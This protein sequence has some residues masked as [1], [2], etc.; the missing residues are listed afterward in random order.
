[1]ANSRKKKGSQGNSDTSDSS[2]RGVGFGDW[3]PT[4]QPILSISSPSHGVGV[5]GSS[6]SF[7][8]ISQPESAEEEGEDLDLRKANPNPF[9]Y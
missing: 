8:P 7:P 3:S 2:S 4:V 1:M 6:V 5:T 9:G